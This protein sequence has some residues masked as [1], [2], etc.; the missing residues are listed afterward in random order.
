VLPR[1]AH[2]GGELLL[3]VRPAKLA[4]SLDEPTEIHFV[5]F[6]D[7]AAIAAYAADEVRQRHLHLKDAAVRAQLVYRSVLVE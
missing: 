3:R 5:R 6:P 4:G 1:L 2:H 7:E